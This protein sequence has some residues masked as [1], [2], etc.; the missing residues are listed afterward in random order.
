LNEVNT[1]QKN[2]VTIED[3]VEYRISGVN[4]VQ[5]APN[6]GLTF[7]AGLR[8][9]LRQ[10]PDIIMV[11]EVRDLE[12]SEICVR[13]ALVGRLVLST[14]HTNDAIGAV[15]RLIDFGIEPFLVSSTL[16]MIIAQRLVR[17]LCPD[18]KEPAKLDAK[19]IDR[20]KLKDTESFS[21]KGCSRCHDRGFIGRMA[22]LEV[23]VADDNLRKMIERRE[24]VSAMRAYLLKNGMKT[25]RE[26]GLDKV[27]QGLTSLNE[28]LAATMEVI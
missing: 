9:F 6:I 14:L 3:P 10:D 15:S 26:D 21:P 8:S 13:S 17:K 22:V 20:Y 4:Q 25:L 16:N 28:V 1:L 27:R 5:A 18:C 19:T 2:I 12:T 24:D 7:A 11:G 23:L